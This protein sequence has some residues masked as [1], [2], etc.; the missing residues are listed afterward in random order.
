VFQE[1]GHGRSAGHWPDA[2]RPPAELMPGDQRLVQQLA[3]DTLALPV[4]NYRGGEHPG[5]PLLFEK[6]YALGLLKGRLVQRFKWW[7]KSSL[8]SSIVRARP[9][10]SAAPARYWA[11]HILFKWKKATRSPSSRR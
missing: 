6:I 10:A 7:W 1:G 3:A 9:G 5:S 8:F 2:Q 4:G 11:G